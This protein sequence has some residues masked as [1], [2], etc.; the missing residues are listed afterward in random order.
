VKGFFN[1]D[2][3][4]AFQDDVG[5]CALRIRGIVYIKCLLV[6]LKGVLKVVDEVEHALGFDGAV[7]FLTNVEFKEFHGPRRHSASKVRFFEY[8]LDVVVDLDSDVVV[9]EVGA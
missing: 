4:G 7:W 5:A 9:F 8:F 6:F 1:E 2:I 3:V